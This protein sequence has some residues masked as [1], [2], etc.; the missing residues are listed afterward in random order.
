MYCA[1]IHKKLTSLKRPY[2]SYGTGGQAHFPLPSLSVKGMTDPVLSLPAHDIIRAASLR[3]TPNEGGS[4][5]TLERGEATVST[6]CYQLDANQ[7][8]IK[9]PKWAKSLQKKNNQIEIDLSCGSD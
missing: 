7:F 8:T 6:H 5:A 9:N 1:S 3:H 2:G 4:S